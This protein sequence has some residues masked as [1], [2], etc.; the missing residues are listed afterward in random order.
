M[1]HLVLAAFLSI[2]FGV[3]TAMSGMVTLYVATDGNDRW[4]GQSPASNAGRTDG[5]LATVQ[6]ARDRARQLRSAVAG[7]GD[8]VTILVRG[9]VYH[10]AEPLV[11]EPQDSGTAESPVI[12]AAYGGEHP[13]LS[14][15]RVIRGC[16]AGTG[17]WGIYLDATTSGYLVENNVVYHTLSGGL[18]YNNGGHENVIRNNIFALSANQTLWPCWEKRPNT[19]QRNIIYLTQ[20]DLMI[21]FA[22]RWLRDRIAGKQSLGVWDE[23]L[24]WHTGGS[25]RLRF[26]RHDLRQWQ[27]MGLDRRSLVADPKFV[28]PQQC[29]FRLQADSPALTLRFQPIDATDAGLY[30]DPAWVEEAQ[31]VKHAKTVL[32]PPPPP[33][34][35]R[36]VNG[37]FRQLHWLGFVSVADAD[38]FFYVDNLKVRQVAGS[39][40]TRRNDENR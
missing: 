23:N 2:S 5:P 29:D 9:G 39:D 33:P 6:A 25:D 28:N 32:P 36:E 22:E 16:K 34:A 35:P 7:A 17:G 12:Y 15:G 26:F 4:S 24:Y 10:L 37:D 11:L 3:Q 13:V 20:G 27:A 40:T 19:F 30:G 14:G 38:T 8:A 18:M 21:P 1:R 31:R